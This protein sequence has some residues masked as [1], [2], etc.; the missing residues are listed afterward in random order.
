MSSQNENICQGCGL[1]INDQ[2]IFRVMPD[3]QWHEACLKCAECSCQ[4][5]ESCFV[6][7]SKTYCRQDYAKLI[8]KACDKC[9]LALKRSDL[10]MKSK[11]KLFHMECFK[12]T[13]CARKLT[14]GDEY[15]HQP[16]DDMLYCK[17][18]ALVASNSN[19]FFINTSQLYLGNYYS[20]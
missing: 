11:D 1:H 18:D 14:P 19:K 4:L 7:N 13:V 5:S 2:Y 6:L 9:G 15:C 16:N 10:I 17:E 3:M 8:K 12:C 20:Y